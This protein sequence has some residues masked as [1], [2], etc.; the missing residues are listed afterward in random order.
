[1]KRFAISILSAVMIMT[2]CG[3]ENVQPE[4]KLE[5]SAKEVN[6][7]SAGGSY[8][9][10]VTHSSDYSVS[11]E[12]SASA[13]LTARIT[14]SGDN[15]ILISVPVYNDYE[16]RTGR[17]T[18]QL[19]S[20]TKY[21]DVLQSKKSAV[22]VDDSDI[23]VGWE[24]GQFSIEVSSNVEFEVDTDAEWLHLVQAKAPLQKNM[25]VFEYDENKQTSRRQ[26]TITIESDANACEISVIQDFRLNDY[27]LRIVHSGSMFT[28]PYVT[29]ILSGTVL[30]GDGSRDDY[31]KDLIHNYKSTGNHVVEISMKGAEEEHVVSMQDIVGVV[32]IDL[33]GM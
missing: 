16:D 30:W 22:V 20:L 21:I 29:G 15:Q 10:N 32:E 4:E 6:F 31:K 18:V 13:W 1:M 12:S 24:K 11:V 19:G 26:A 25:L 14:G 33:S 9:V 2:G 23:N 8:V 17:I 3:V 28:V 27:S 7:K 5:L